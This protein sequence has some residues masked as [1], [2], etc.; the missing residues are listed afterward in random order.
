MDKKELDDIADTN[1]AKGTA[2]IVDHPKTTLVVVVVLA[3][4]LVL[5]IG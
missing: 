5:S 1:I 4:L 2:W 3:I